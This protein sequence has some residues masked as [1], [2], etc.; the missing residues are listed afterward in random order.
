MEMQSP[1][2]SLC[3]L[4]YSVVDPLAIRKLILITVRKIRY[5]SRAK[6]MF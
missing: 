3:N 4:M 1:N 5:K 2:R 6:L